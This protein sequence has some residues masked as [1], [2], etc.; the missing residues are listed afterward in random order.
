M[1]ISSIRKWAGKFGKG[2]GTAAVEFALIAPMMIAI[3]MATVELTA[4]LLIERKI[5]AATET[6]ADLV[7][8]ESVITPAEVDDVIVA[9]QRIFDPYSTTSLSI[10]IASVRYNTTSGAPEI[11]WQRI[12]GT[13]GGSSVL[14][15]AVGLGQ[16]GEGVVIAYL[17]YSYTPMFGTLITD[18]VFLEEMSFLRPRRS[19]VVKCSTTSST[20]SS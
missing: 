2:R 3:Y 19:P 9:A 1:L 4:L 8:Q 7:S 16:P 10:N 17:T 14:T 18:T 11:E 13:T 6:V 5:V 20:C 12:V 15:Q